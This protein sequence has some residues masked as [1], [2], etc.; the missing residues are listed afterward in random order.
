MKLI[1]KSS[2]P[3]LSLE[4]ASRILEQAFKA[5]EMENNTIPL[6]VLASYSNYRKERFTLQR[7]ILV[8]IMT[9]F[10]LLPLLFIP[11]AFHVDEDE[12]L[13][14]NYNPVYRLEVDSFMLVER[15]NATIDGYNI[16]VYE[17]DSHVY[18]IEPS[19]NGQMAVT[20]T[21]TNRQTMTQYVDVTEVDREV[22]TV[23]SCSKVGDE[24]HLYLSDAG[25]GVDYS[26]I[27]AYG[28]DGKEIKPVE[29]D[30]E[31]G[32]VIL[33]AAS[34]TIN[35]YVADLAENKLQLILTIGG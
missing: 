5:N 22:P 34:D 32:F 21:L 4:E 18:S 7:T 23:V 33:P 11:V 13:A 8:I 29:I 28:L 10:I 2:A 35:V 24:L 6:E 14:R 26:K 1:H 19:R 16:P 12:T 30:E 15:V 17:V 25:S 31:T 3:Q 20:V 27:E 9:L